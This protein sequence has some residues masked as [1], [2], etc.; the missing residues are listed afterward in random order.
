M[1]QLLVTLV[2]LGSM[3]FARTS[4]AN[5]VTLSTG[6]S[7]A[8]NDGQTILKSEQHFTLPKFPAAPTAPT[9]GFSS[10]YQIHH[11]DSTLYNFMYFS[12]DTVIVFGVKKYKIEVT[13][14]S[15]NSAGLHDGF[16]TDYALPGDAIDWFYNDFS[17]VNS[18]R[19]VNT[20]ASGHIGWDHSGTFSWIGTHPDNHI[21]AEYFYN[22]NNLFGTLQCAQDMPA[23]DV[24][25]SSSHLATMA[26]ISAI[27]LLDG[28]L[29][30]TAALSTGTSCGMSVTYG[31][32]GPY[33]YSLISTYGGG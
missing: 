4:F 18:V 22:V 21:H 19:I 11:I 28:T 9:A 10:H 14:Q 13:Y 29:I 25:G 5:R 6:F 24:L 2:L 7:G 20:A 8:I 16:L 33:I 1:K 12:V 32:Y 23:Q 26:E 27:T 30:S 15:I 17:G 3:L 31:T